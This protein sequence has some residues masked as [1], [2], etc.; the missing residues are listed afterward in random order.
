M[1]IAS[2][3]PVK[4]SWGNKHVLHVCHHAEPLDK[5]QFK[6]PWIDV[7]GTLFPPLTFF[8]VLLPRTTLG[9]EKDRFTK[10]VVCK[11]C[12]SLS[13]F[14]ECHATINGKTIAKKIC[15][16]IA[17]PHHHQPHRREPCNEPLLKE[18]ILKEWQVSFVPI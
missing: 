15:S 4:L 9:L 1:H 16:Y 7:L 5:K 11:N 10:F 2:K 18:V 17:F 3:T 13:S 14:D 8:T 12:S 6:T